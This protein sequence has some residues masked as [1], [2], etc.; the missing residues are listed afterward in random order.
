GRHNYSNALAALALGQAV[1]LPLDS[2]LKAL[3]EYRGLAHRC[4]VVAERNGVR[5]VDDSKGTN[6]G[7]TV[8]AMHSL[9]EMIRG[10]LIL[11]AGGDGKGADFSPLQEPA[12][13]WEIGRAH[14]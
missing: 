1:G 5:Y 7:A 12:Q 4:Q 9:G 2:M 11:I 8:A 3:R 13:R 10:K 6:V 14:V